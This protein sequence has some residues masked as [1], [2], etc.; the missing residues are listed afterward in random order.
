HKI[1]ASVTLAQAIFE[2]GCGSSNLAKRSNN[3]FGI[4]CHAEWNGDTIVKND[5]SYNECFRSYKTVHESYTDHSNF[6]RSRARYKHLFRLRIT[7]YRGWCN[8]LKNSGYATYMYYPEVLIK[9]IE[10]YSLYKYDIAQT[11]PPCSLICSQKQ[12]IKASKLNYMDFTFSELCNNDMMWNDEKYILIQSLEMVINKDAICD[13]KPFKKLLGG[14]LICSRNNEITESKLTP[15]GFS[16]KQ[17]SANDLLW[18]D[19]KYFLIQSL[20]M[21][22]DHPEK[23][24]DLFVEK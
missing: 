10:Q 1:P 2:S 11:L 24:K 15:T 17:F 23:E 9:I 8:G 3:H 22:I 13:N 14:T 5:D 12:E 21:I 20:E 16:L 18:T 19:E 7:D 4:K 6:L